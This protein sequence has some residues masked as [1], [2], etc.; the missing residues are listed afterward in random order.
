MWGLM[1][2]ARGSGAHWTAGRS[3]GEEGVG[4]G[5][6]GSKGGRGQGG[7]RSLTFPLPSTLLLSCHPPTPPDLKTHSSSTSFSRAKACIKRIGAT[8]MLDQD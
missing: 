8:Q 1:F 4:K 6:K 2:L 7:L 5:G 3:A